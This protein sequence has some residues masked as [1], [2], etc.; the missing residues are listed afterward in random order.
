LKESEQE[1]SEK[2]KLAAI[3]QLAAGIAHELNTP[4]AN[5]NLTVEYF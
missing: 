2:S 1:L 5:I 3:G 4:L